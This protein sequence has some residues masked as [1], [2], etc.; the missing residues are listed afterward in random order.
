MTKDNEEWGNVS[1]PGLDDDKLFNT[2]W[3]HVAAVRDRNLDPKYH[4]KKLDALRAVMATQEWKDANQKSIEKWSNDPEWYNDQLKR[5]EKRQENT[6]WR[7]NVG[8]ASVITHGKCCITPYGIFP[9]VQQAGLY[10]D[11]QRG[12]KCG[13]TVVCRNLKKGTPGYQYIDQEEY[14]LL[15]GKD[16]V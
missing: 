7:S 16:I 8:K 6:E 15:T 2:N 12:T 14:I 1:L 11:K 9:S 4:Q 3:N 13:V 5:V 10:R